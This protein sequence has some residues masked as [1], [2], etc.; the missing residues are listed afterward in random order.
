VKL[1]GQKLDIN[2]TFTFH[3]QWKTQYNF[4]PITAIYIFDVTLS[5]NAETKYTYIIGST[6]I[7][8]QFTASLKTGTA[9]LAVNGNTN[10]IE[11]TFGLSL[12]H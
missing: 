4:P 12:A 10:N 6:M 5:P 11:E 8:L 3:N 2:L 9:S 1:V 7:P